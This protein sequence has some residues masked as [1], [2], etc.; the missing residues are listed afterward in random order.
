MGACR[1]PV[2]SHLQEVGIELRKCNMAGVRFANDTNS[3]FFTDCC[4]TAIF[5]YETKC[6]RC[7]EGVPYTPRERWRMAMNR[8]CGG[9]YPK[10]EVKDD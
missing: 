3:T 1:S 8:P 7:G 10:R 2:K 9:P 5:D 4:G 6:G